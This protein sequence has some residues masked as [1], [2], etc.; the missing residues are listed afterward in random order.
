[1]SEYPSRIV[2][3]HLVGQLNG[4][5]GLIDTGSGLQSEPRC[6]QRS[7]W[8]AGEPRGWGHVGQGG[9]QGRRPGAQSTGGG[10]GRS[11]SL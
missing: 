6:H 2:R 5:L 8:R 9:A 1:M 10:A 11:A 7:G 4:G 3:D